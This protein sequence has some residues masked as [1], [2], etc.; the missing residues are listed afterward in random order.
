MAICFQL[1]CLENHIAVSS[2]NHKIKIQAEYL[3]SIPETLKMF[4]SNNKLQAA[5]SN[6]LI[7][8]HFDA[9]YD[10]VHIFQE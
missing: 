1:E 4:S 10:K 9:R 2:N 8:K 6:A 7:G 3:K 5:D